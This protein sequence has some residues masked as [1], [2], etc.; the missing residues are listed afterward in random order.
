M[1]TSN[2]SYEEEKIPYTR[3]FAQNIRDNNEGP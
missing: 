2:T 3:K 1:L